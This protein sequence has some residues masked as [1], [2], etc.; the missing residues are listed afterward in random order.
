MHL[1]LVSYLNKK[2]YK[3]WS[4][5]TLLLLALPFVFTTTESDQGDLYKIAICLHRSYFIIVES[6][7]LSDATIDEYPE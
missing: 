1:H 7:S 5:T 6:L 3:A 4:L 2:S